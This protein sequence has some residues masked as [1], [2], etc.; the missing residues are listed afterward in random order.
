M[1]VSCVSFHNFMKTLLIIFCVTFSE[2]LFE[3]SSSESYHKNARIT[4]MFCLLSYI[5]S[6]FQTKMVASVF[7]AWDWVIMAATM[8]ASIVI[9]LYFRFSGG[10]QATNEVIEYIQYCITTYSFYANPFEST[11]SYNIFM[12][13]KG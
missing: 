5:F 9:G 12:R 11:P 13:G 1:E 7:G 10:K 2:K 8:I 3:K 4:R 6:L